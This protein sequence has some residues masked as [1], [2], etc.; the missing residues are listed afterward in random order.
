MATEAVAIKKL[1]SVEDLADYLGVPVK[2]LYDWRHRGYGPRSR[3]IGRYI[4]YKPQDVFDWFDSL[5]A[6]SA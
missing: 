3:R 5:D 6:R 2:T 4:R 1:W